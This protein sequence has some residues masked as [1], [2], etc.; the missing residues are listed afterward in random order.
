MI[1]MHSQFPQGRI[2]TRKIA[3]RC[4]HCGEYVH[5]DNGVKMKYHLERFCTKNPANQKSD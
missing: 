3:K 2:N 4:P 1:I 5:K